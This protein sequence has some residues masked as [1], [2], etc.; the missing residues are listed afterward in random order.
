MQAWGLPPPLPPPIRAT[1]VPPAPQ[2]PSPHQAAGILHVHSG[3]V[4][5]IFP[6]LSPASQSQDPRRHTGRALAR[7]D[8]PQQLE[9]SG[10]NC[11]LE[12]PA[13]QPRNLGANFRL[14]DQRAQRG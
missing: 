14:K 9:T 4:F 8:G 6:G 3:L 11:R 5:P 12:A 10:L 13:R 7:G 2:L 1:P